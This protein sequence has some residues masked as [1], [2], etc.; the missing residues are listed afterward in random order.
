MYYRTSEFDAGFGMQ[1]SA[2][3]EPT[4]GGARHAETRWR[5][6]VRTIG[7][8]AKRVADAYRQRRNDRR[9]WIA[10]DM[11]DDHMLRDLGINRTDF[12][13]RGRD[14]AFRSWSRMTRWC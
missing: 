7:H 13:P 9:A 1:P 4:R 5:A 8:L 6:A 10:L 2:I 14:H 3:S 11:M 12:G